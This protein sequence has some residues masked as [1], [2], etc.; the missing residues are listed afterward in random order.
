VREVFASTPS[1]LRTRRRP[2]QVSATPGMMRLRLAVRAPL[3]DGRLF[4]FF[5][6]RAVVGVETG[7]RSHY[8]RSLRLPRGGGVAVLRPAGDY[9]E[10]DLHLDDVADTQAAVHRCRRMLDLDADPMAIDALLGA[11][12]V[13]G[14]LVALRP[15]VR[16]PGHPDGAELVVR[17]VLGQQ[18][19][20][21]GARTTAGRL[22]ERFGEAVTTPVGGV[23][24]RFPSAAAL[25]AADVT[26]IPVPRT[27]GR[28]LIEVC[29]RLS[30]GELV[31]DDGASRD[32]VARQLQT[33]PGI[34]P[35][36]AS[37]VA[38]RAL[39]DPD[40]FLP[41]DIGVRN[42]LRGLGVPSDAASASRFADAW[43]PFRS[44]A[45]HH[46][47]ISLDQESRS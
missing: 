30:E 2:N 20:V 6:A 43:R 24:H 14:P 36:T 13:L 38:M 16:S 26:D 23:T 29:R 42:A 1:E 9:V 32:D 28:A 44:Y 17:A 34:G 5:A 10:C 25:A 21:S 8:A 19:S 31:V 27:R 15:G 4:G 3:D 11:D 40:V 45:L 46:L 33:V 7:D 47:W 18:V 22:V 12:P 41:T 37:Y 35:W 39:G